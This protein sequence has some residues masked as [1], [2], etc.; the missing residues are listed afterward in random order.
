M[1]QLHLLLEHSLQHVLRRL[2]H[3][4]LLDEVHQTLQLTPRLRTDA[5]IRVLLQSLRRGMVVSRREEH[6]HGESTELHVVDVVLR[7]VDARHVH[8]RHVR[9]VPGERVHV[10]LHLLAELA[11]LRV[12]SAPR[13]HRHNVLH[14]H[15]HVRVADE[16][17]VVVSHQ[18]LH[19]PVALGIRRLRANVRLQLA[20]E[21]HLDVLAERGLLEDAAEGVLGDLVLAAVHLRER[22]TKRG[23]C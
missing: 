21:E 13:S 10:L 9:E 16:R 23:R 2:L 19:V 4:V 8:V 14:Q 17:L 12:S 1:A 11:V 5:E 7:H 20:A 3:P 18:H 15:V 6:E 22:E